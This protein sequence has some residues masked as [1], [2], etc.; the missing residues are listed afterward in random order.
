MSDSQ[1]R[2]QFLKDLSALHQQTKAFALRVD[3]QG[4]VL[5]GTT[6][7]KSW[8]IVQAFEDAIANLTKEYEDHLE[9]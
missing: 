9:R 3:Q 5:G 7:Q 2:Q 4:G 1:I 8:D 6:Q